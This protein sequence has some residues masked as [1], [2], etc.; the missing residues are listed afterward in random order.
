MIDMKYSIIVPVFNRE[1]TIRTCLEGL[2]D[3]SFSDFEI[4]VVDDGSSDD[5]YEASLAV[6]NNHSN[7]R[8]IK[9]QE[10]KGLSA[11]RNVG[12]D[13]ARG[14]YLIF[15]DSDDTFVKDALSDIDKLVTDNLDLLMYGIKIGKYKDKCWEQREYPKTVVDI[16]LEG[17][18]RIVEWIYTSLETYKIQYYFTAYAKVLNKALIDKHN[19]RFQEDVTFGEDQVFTCNYLQFVDSFRYSN[20]PYYN[21][22]NWPAT[23]LQSV[24]RLSLCPRTPDNFLHNQT[25][26]Y[27]ALM[28]LSKSTGLESVH[29]YAI[30]YILD[31]PITRILFRQE[32]VRNKYRL[33]YSDLKAVT[34]MKIKPMLAVE[35]ENVGKLKSKVIAL[36]VDM[37]LKDKPF[38]MVYSMIFIH[39]NV[40][41]NLN[42]F[43]NTIY[44]KI[45]CLG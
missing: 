45:A 20:I 33:S 38:W 26:N 37:I 30:N 23:M 28:N 27:E 16:K 36:Y 39:R 10:N 18:R 31:R 19:L 43:L 41:L 4:I 24:D 2:L 8:V 40:I 11:A 25:A 32:D 9:R 35:G 34:K 5:S 21:I 7:V 29:E 42:H 17:N 22:I 1:K 44:R 14:E 12:M 15:I 13:N 3:T 6:A